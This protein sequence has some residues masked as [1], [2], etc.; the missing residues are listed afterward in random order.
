MMQSIS[1]TSS[2]KM[3]RKLYMDHFPFPYYV[4]MKDI[5]SLPQ[6]LADALRQWFEA[7]NDK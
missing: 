6:I 5:G 7:L 1:Q 3:M 2:G 4:V